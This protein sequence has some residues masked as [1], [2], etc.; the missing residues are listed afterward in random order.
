MKRLIILILLLVV[1]AIVLTGCLS[2]LEG[3]ITSEIEHLIQLPDRPPE[4]QIEVSNYDDLM[5]EMLKL[6]MQHENSSRMYAYNY[7]G[8]VTM[9]VQRVC[10]EIR[11]VDPVSAYAVLDIAGISTRIVSYYEIDFTIEYRRTKQQVDSIVNASTTRFMETELLDV[12]KEYGDEAVFRTNLSIT[13]EYITELVKSVYFENPRNI[14]IM[15][16]AETEIF[17][18]GGKDS[19]VEVRLKYFEPVDE[20]QERGNKLALSIRENAEKAAGE[21]DA[22]ILLSLVENLMISR[23][24]DVFRAEIIKEHGALDFAATAYSALI[25]K[26]ATGEGYA[27]AFK[28]LC[29]ELKFECYVVPGELN[30]K[31]YAWNIVYLSGAYYHIDVAMCIVNGIQTAFLKTDADFADRYAWDMVKMKTCKGPMTYEDIVG[32]EETD[33]IQDDETGEP[34]EISENN[35]SNTPDASGDELTTDTPEQTEDEPETTDT[36]EQPDGEPGEA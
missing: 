1:S 22:I 26:R 32:I 31:S 4:E 20:L 14:V 23:T 8:D 35:V 30:E 2:I 10:R 12:I 18:T 28:A 3:D 29:D 9:D 13:E 6:V 11:D 16:V 27:M 24:Y 17:P 5:E 15:P 25:D 33:E 21:N 36:P 7:D 34:G 19:I